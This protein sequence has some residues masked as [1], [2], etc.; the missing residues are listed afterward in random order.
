LYIDV[1][2]LSLLS[3]FELITALVLERS[4]PLRNLR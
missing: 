4:F 1:N 2:E 3:K